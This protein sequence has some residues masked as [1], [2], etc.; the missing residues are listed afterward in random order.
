MPPLPLVGGVAPSIFETGPRHDQ[1]K[2]FYIELLRLRTASLARVFDEVFSSY[3]LR[4]SR[5]KE[6]SWRDEVERFAVD[7]VFRWLVGVRIDVDKMRSLYNN[8]FTDFFWRLNQWIPWSQ[9]SQSLG[10]YREAVK[11]VQ[12]GDNFAELWHIASRYGAFEK[13]YLAKQ[14][15]F[16][17]GMNSYLG[18][19]CLLKSIIGHIGNHDITVAALSG[20]NKNALDSMWRTSSFPLDKYILEIL[21]LHPPVFFIFGRAADDTTINASEQ[22]FA[23]AKG[24]LIMG[25]I[26]FIQKDPTIFPNPA[27]FIPERF[28][29]TDAGVKLVW[30]RGD[31][32]KAATGSDRTCPGKDAALTI[33]RVFAVKILTEMNWSLDRSA[34]WTNISYNLNVAAPVG[35]MLTKTFS[36][37]NSRG[38]S[39][40]AVA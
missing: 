24:E 30:P 40:S 29:G 18:L 5:L 31:P 38:E 23:I 27:A 22:D 28:E 15:I 14:L 26:P 20:L 13:T 25:V 8:I 3:V 35:P 1:P 6:F 4:W 17:T 36:L 16:L 34:E 32:S 7:F 19:Q 10:Y 2:E 33:A 39:P 9:Y 37:R 21:R 11:E 12:F